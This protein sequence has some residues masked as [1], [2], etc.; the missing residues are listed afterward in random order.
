MRFSW[1]RMD[2]RYGPHVEMTSDRIEAP[3]FL[4]YLAI[5]VFQGPNSGLLSLVPN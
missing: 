1:L 2:N 5:E 3:D 4:R